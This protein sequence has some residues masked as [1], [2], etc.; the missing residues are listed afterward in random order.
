MS[1]FLCIYLPDWDIQARRVKLRRADGMLSHN[2]SPL[3]LILMQGRQEVVGRCCS[4][5]RQ[6]GIMPGMAVAEARALLPNVTASPFDPIESHAL[7]EKLARWALRFSPLISIGEPYSDDELRPGADYLLLNIGGMEHLD[8]G[9]M[10]MARRIKGV[11]RHHH[12]IGRI[13]IAPTIGS[14]I[15]LARYAPTPAIMEDVADIP[16][17]M[18]DFPPAALR[19][20]AATQMALREVGMTRLGEI[21]AIARDQLAARFPAELLLRLDQ[22]LGRRMELPPLITES[23]VPAAQW[24]AEGAVENL[25]GILL[26]GRALT[27]QLARELLQRNMGTTRLAVDMAGADMGTCTITIPLAQPVRQQDRLWAAIRP[28][29]EQLQLTGG[30]ETLTIRAMDTHVL[31]AEQLHTDT[32]TSWQ[33]TPA[34]ASLA[35]VLDILRT[36]VPSTRIGM[37][38]GGRSHLPEHALRIHALHNAGNITA[39]TDDF[40]T[41]QRPSLLLSPPELVQVVTNGP[42][43]PPLQIQWRGRIYQSIRGA[44]PERITTPWWRGVPPVTRDY[45]AVLDQTGQWLWMFNELQSRQWFVHGLWV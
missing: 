22:L 6:H 16:A 36:R 10:A 42:D 37:A 9:S 32:C 12:L 38:K 45:F 43:A 14:A 4:V 44:G 35:P 11:L 30:V 39:G 27:E 1:R 20:T 18:A 21:M 34:M 7:L 2:P 33:S 40:I 23:T 29:M 41:A 24:R 17:I 8:G 3:L 31:L 15:A 19:I 13:A 28:R 5:C 26:A 25:E